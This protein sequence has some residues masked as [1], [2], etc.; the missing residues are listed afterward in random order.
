MISIR[1]DVPRPSS[2]TTA[3][4]IGDSKRLGLWPQICRTSECVCS[5]TETEPLE[6]IAITRNGGQNQVPSMNSETSL[7]KRRW[8][9]GVI[10]RW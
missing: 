4:V 2:A 6:P 10:G 7:A 1:A 5:E 8:S 3:S 9:Y